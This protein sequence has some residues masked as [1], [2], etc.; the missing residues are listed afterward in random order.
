[1]N[2]FL[3][4]PRILFATKLINITIRFVFCRVDESPQA[5]FNSVF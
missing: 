5:E 3:Y 1:M 2:C 4:H